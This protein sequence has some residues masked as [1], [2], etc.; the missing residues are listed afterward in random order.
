MLA[1]AQRAAAITT[2]PLSADQHARRIHVMLCAGN[3][4]AFAAARA[5]EVHP[6]RPVHGGALRK[7]QRKPPRRAAGAGVVAIGIHVPF[8][9]VGRTSIVELVAHGNPPGVGALAGSRA[10]P[11]RSMSALHYPV[12]TLPP[13]TIGRS[14]LSRVCD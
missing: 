5:G 1:D 4:H 8:P 13:F 2:D 11:G 6:E 9:G 3:H 12:E 7:G 14:A 10:A